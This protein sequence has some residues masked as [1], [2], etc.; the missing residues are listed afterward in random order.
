LIVENAPLVE[1]MRVGQG[2]R[3]RSGGL[4]LTV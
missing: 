2:R 3:M 4:N 1:H